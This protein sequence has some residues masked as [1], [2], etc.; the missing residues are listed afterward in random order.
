MQFRGGFYTSDIN[1]MDAPIVKTVGPTG[2]Y[3]HEINIP[4]SP[5]RYFY[6]TTTFKADSSHLLPRHYG[7][8]SYMGDKSPAF[9]PPGPDNQVV[10]LQMPLQRSFA[11]NTE[12]VLLYGNVIIGTELEIF[13]HSIPE[14]VIE[15]NREDCVT[16]NAMNLKTYSNAIGGKAYDDICYN[17]FIK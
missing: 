15:I 12:I 5:F 7:V 3:H 14:Q 13:F 1:V 8:K 4:N 11:T 17:A 16:D 6:R 9:Q 10:I 2:E